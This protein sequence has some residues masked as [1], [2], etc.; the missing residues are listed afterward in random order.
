VK[1]AFRTLQIAFMLSVLIT[2]FGI[3]HVIGYP[4]AA[5]GNSNLSQSSLGTD[6]PEP[7]FLNQSFEA[8]TP[9]TIPS[10]W[11]VTYP[12]YGTIIVDGTGIGGVGRCAMIID[13][14]SVGN[15]C[16]YT[17]FPEQVNTI[18]VSFAMK[19]TNNSGTNTVI[20]VFVDDGNFNGANIIFQNGKIG[21]RQ[22]DGSIFNLRDSYIPDRWYRIRL[23]LNIPHNVYNIHIDDHLEAIGAQFFGA[24]NE[25]HRIVFNETSGYDGLVL[26]V[27]YIDDLLG[28]KC[29]EIPRDYATIQEGIDAANESDIVYATGQRT[30]YESIVIT[31]SIELEG[32]DMS[33]TVID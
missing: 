2:G 10:N 22:K 3:G 31:K 6:P 23:V 8:E 14:S 7:V 21:Y 29:I 24:C 13:N 27:A 30:Y 25:L 26:P 1:S 12:Q 4:S 17:Y 9:G 33:T 32:E 28:R 5:R 18:G 15:P 19:P 20:E 16:P 11:Y